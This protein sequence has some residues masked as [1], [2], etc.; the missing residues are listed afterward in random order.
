MSPWLLAMSIGL[1]AGFAWSAGWRTRPLAALRVIGVFLLACLPVMSMIRI[2]YDHLGSRLVYFPV[3]VALIAL[4]NQLN[5]I[6]KTG[7]VFIAFLAALWGFAGKWNAQSWEEAGKERDRTLAAMTAAASIYPHGSTLLLDARQTL[8]GAYVFNNGL[9]EAARLLEL[10]GNHLWIQGSASELNESGRQ[11]LGRDMFELSLGPES[12]L[13]DW[14]DCALRPPLPS[15]GP[16][17]HWNLPGDGTHAG[18]V[19]RQLFL[20]PYPITVAAGTYWVTLEFSVST[21]KE[22]SG[23]LYWRC[24]R[25]FPFLA[26][27]SRSF[28][29]TPGQTAARIRLLPLKENAPFIQLRIDFNPP[30]ESGQLH[31]VS[32]STNPQDCGPKYPL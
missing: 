22:Q 15:S 14:T 16:L 9:D 17:F 25:R 1:I 19:I 3:A 18:Q 28:R 5:E 12:Q 24:D 31:N 23:L 4:G 10:R 11:R 26:G 20:R 21:N 30:L 8:R 13:V 7:L 6:R 29:L 27:D 32:L 2:E